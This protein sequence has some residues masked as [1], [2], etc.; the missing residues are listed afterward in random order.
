MERIKSNLARWYPNRS[1]TQGN[2]YGIRPNNKQIT[3]S[4]I[5]YSGPK[6]WNQI[7]SQQATQN[8]CIL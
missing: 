5:S 3:N 6:L 4:V 1:A 2:F 8:P 7:T